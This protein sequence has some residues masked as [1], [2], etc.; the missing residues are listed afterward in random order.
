VSRALAWSGRP[1]H[2]VRGHWNQEF[3]A[4]LLAFPQ[5]QHD[6]QVDAVSGAVQMLADA[7]PLLLW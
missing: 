2:L 4:E 3:V 5:G 1:L 7:G 6:D